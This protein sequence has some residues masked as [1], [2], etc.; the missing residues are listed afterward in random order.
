MIFKNHIEN[1]LKGLLVPLALIGMGGCPP[2]DPPYTLDRGE[3]IVIPRVAT[4]LLSSCGGTDED[5]EP[6]GTLFSAA[7]L[8]RGVCG[9]T[10]TTITGW[11]A[12][13]D[14]ADVFALPMN[15]GC[16]LPFLSSYNP[17][18]RRTQLP[19]TAVV[20]ADP[21]T[22][23]CF[24]GSCDYG[25]TNRSG[26]T[27]GNARASRLE[28]GMFGCCITGPGTFTTG[29]L[30]DSYSPSISGFIVVKGTSQDCHPDNYEIAFSISD[31]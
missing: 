2:Y 29:I 8:G 27:G 22:E 9:S 5:T 4:H 7:Q 11:L 31:P 20:K 13:Q 30:C 12:T 21:T 28:E 23:V 19:K 6:N 18:D 15:S 1:R 17:L 24:F 16:S 10:P 3:T 26:C 14:D 25:V